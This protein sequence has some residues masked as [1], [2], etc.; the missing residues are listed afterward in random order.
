MLAILTAFA[1][2][3]AIL[4]ATDESIY[5]AL[6]AEEFINKNTW[7]GYECTSAIAQMFR[8]RALDFRFFGKWHY[9]LMKYEEYRLN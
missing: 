3:F 2:V 5:Y 1:G 9:C 4:G 6:S 8:S 7:L